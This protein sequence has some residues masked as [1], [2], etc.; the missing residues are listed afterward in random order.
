MIGPI[1]II[2]KPEESGS[3]A[4][5]V[6]LRLHPAIHDDAIKLLSRI[7]N[8]PDFADQA[9]SSSTSTSSPVI[10][11]NDLRGEID[12][13]EIMGPKAT[14]V[15]RRIFRLVKSEGKD[16]ATVSYPCC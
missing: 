3:A 8:A 12:S 10:R 6:W 16:K 9:A 7:L 4:R 13:F 11:L 15:L 14:R 2:W 5:A 1:D